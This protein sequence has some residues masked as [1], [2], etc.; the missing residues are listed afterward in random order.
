MNYK[1][2]FSVTTFN[3][4]APCYHKVELSDCSTQQ[5]QNKRQPPE[6]TI[7]AAEKLN[8][9]N[10]ECVTSPRIARPYSPTS[11]SNRS[12]VPMSALKKWS[13]F[14]L[15]SIEKYRGSFSC[16]T[17]E[18][19]TKYRWKARAQK[20]VD[21]IKEQLTTD[22]ICLQEY[23]CTQPEWC[24]IFQE[25]FSREY[26]MYTAKRSGKK[27]DGLFTMVRR[28]SCW[29]VVDTEV[30]Y[31]HDCG[32]RLLLATVLSLNKAEG[33]LQQEKE[34]PFQMLLINTH[35]S[36]PH[37]SWGLSLRLNEVRKLLDFVD[38]YLELHPGQ[39]K[40]VVLVGD[41]NATLEDPVCE[42]I[43][44]RGFTNS[45]LLTHGNEN[46]VTHCNHN[47][48]SLP[49][50]KVYYKLVAPYYNNA[51]ENVLKSSQIGS[52]EMTFV[53]SLLTENT[54]VR[55]IPVEATVFPPH[56]GAEQWPTISE[57]NLS[58]HRPLRVLFQVQFQDV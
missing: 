57:Y 25:N 45:Y 4:L 12:L 1:A 18:S 34:V 15:E 6:R 36:F 56:L 33:D 20:L 44:S 32:E 30:Y 26:E 3:L 58:D 2:H 16:K 42:Q 24:S 37:G 55:M 23:W 53:T 5:Q 49:V 22:V 46:V 48:H 50:D 14:F 27:A 13:Q 9:R 51:A 47:G 7:C 41:F 40:A 43:V 52:S 29:K 8:C 31:F 11:G 17:L 10:G 19:Q 35:L 38:S 28:N 39:V 21:F 54:K